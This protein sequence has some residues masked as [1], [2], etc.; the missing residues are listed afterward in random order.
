MEQN[1]IRLCTPTDEAAAN[2]D[3]AIN[4]ISQVGIHLVEIR[5]VNGINVIDFT[6]EQAKEFYNKLKAKDIKVWAISSPIGKNDLHID[7]IDYQKRVKKIIKIAKI[8]HAPHIRVFSF[9]KHNNNADEVIKRLRYVVAIASKERIKVCLENEKDSYGETPERMLELL[10]KIPNMLMVYDSSNYV[11][12]GV[13][14]AKTLAMA[15]PHAYYVHFKDGI[16]KNDDADIV[17]VGEGEANIIKLIELVNKD[18]I[19]SIEHHLRFPRGNETYQQIKNVQKFVYP[20]VTAA[21][22]DA[23]MHAKKMLLKVGYKEVDEGIFKK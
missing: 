7:F 12:V 14:S 4:A 18:M 1:V 2:I 23:V 5:D 21:F 8:F 11:Q 20:S 19:F 16:H 10:E 13:P 22:F 17:P 15:F 6:S 3:D 9:F